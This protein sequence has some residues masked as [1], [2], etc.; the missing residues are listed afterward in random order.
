MHSLYYDVPSLCGVPDAD[1][2]PVLH[3]ARADLDQSRD[4]A[5]YERDAPVPDDALDADVAL[6]LMHC[7]DHFHFENLYLEK[8]FVCCFP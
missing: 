4:D 2:A 5:L 8:D 3:V 6:L 1:D 7:F